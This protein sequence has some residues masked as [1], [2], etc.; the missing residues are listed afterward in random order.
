MSCS[1]DNFR[2]KFPEWKRDDIKLSSNPQENELTQWADA[3]NNEALEQGFDKPLF[4]FEYRYTDALG[5][6]T[7]R[8]NNVHPNRYLIVNTENHN[9][10]EQFLEEEYLPD[11]QYEQNMNDTFMQA[12]ETDVI[13]SE[14]ALT[15]QEDRIDYSY[16]DA[17][18]SAMPYDHTE[19]NEL[20]DEPVNFREWKETRINLLNS[21]NKA[22]S[23]L[24]NRKE[25]KTKL[26]QI[27]SAIKDLELEL[28]EFEDTNPN[29]VHYN[30]ISEIN[31]L[32]SLLSLNE[33]D[34]VQAAN[35]LDTNL[36]L[37]RLENLE[38]SFYNEAFA[39]GD[40]YN[41]HAG[42]KPE[43]VNEIVKKVIDLR[44]KYENS[45][46]HLIFNIINNNE[47]ILQQKQYFESQGREEEFNDFI[48]RVKQLLDP[49]NTEYKIDGD[50]LFGK[51]LLGAGSYDSILAEVII[52]TR[53]IHKSKEAGITNLWR[54]QLKDSYDK[55][56]AVKVGD[57]YFAD[58]LF[59]KDEFGVRTQKLIN[60]VTPDFYSKLKILSSANKEFYYSR[61]SDKGAAYKDWMTV[62][63]MNV[64][65]I[66]PHKI[67]SF[68]EKY[69][70]NPDFTEFFTSSQ[71]EMEA[72]EDNMRRNLGDTAFELELE[73][74]ISSVTDYLNDDFTTA[75]DKY[76]K[77]P[78]RY[79][80]N[81]YSDNFDKYDT[82]T[83]DFLLPN[84]V[85]FIPNLSN[86]E[87]YN[88]EFKNVENIGIEG[89]KDF[90]TS[91]KNLLDYTR[92]A[93][94]SEG[95]NVNFNDII[96]LRDSA[97]REVKKN[98]STFQGIWLDLKTIAK[99]LFS[100]FYEGRLE[101]VEDDKDYQRKFN[102]HYSNY[103]AKEINEMTT[104]LAGKNLQSLLELAEKE[105]ISVPEK[106][107][108][109]SDFNRAKIANSI[110]RN[111]INK[112]ISLDLF[113]RI[114]YGA[115]LAESINTR[116][117]TMS[118]LNLIKDYARTN[119]VKNTLSYVETWE[120]NNILQPGYLNH[121]RIGKLERVKMKWLPKVY[122][123]AEQDLIK[124]YEEE[125][126]N[127]DGN[128]NFVYQGFKYFTVNGEI[129]KQD[130]DANTVNRTTKA[131]VDA[132]YESY[133]TDKISNLGKNARVGTF[134]FGL[135][136]N[137]F[138]SYL[139]VSLPSG[140]KNRMAGYNQN[141]E[142][143]ASNL[144]GFN[145]DNLVNA[146]KLLG[147]TNIR[148]TLNYTGLPKTVGLINT[149]KAQQVDVLMHLVESLGLLEN[150]MSDA[151]AGDGSSSFIGQDKYNKFK[152]F[153]SDFAMNNPEFHNQ[154]EILVAMMQNVEITKKDGTP[155]KLYDPKTMSF[156][157][158]PKTMKLLDE[159]RTEENIKNWEQFIADDNGN[160]PQSILIQQFTNTKHKLHGNYRP[161]DKIGIQSTMTG[162][163]LT[164]FM[165]WAYEN[166]NNQYGTK[167]VSLATAQIEVKGRKIPII[168]RFPLLGTH[169]L[170]QNVGI[171]TMVGTTIGLVTG[172]TPLILGG[173]GVVNA[174]ILGYL[175][176]K[177]KKNVKF[178]WDDFSLS[179]NYLTEIL[180]RTLKTATL[181]TTRGLVNP[182]SES[183]I[184]NWS[185]RNE[186]TYKDRNLDLKTRRLIS[187]S[188]QEVAN[189]FNMSIQFMI[190]GLVLKA[191]YTLMFTAPGDDEEEKMKKLENIE[192][193]LKFL[194]NTKNNLTSDIEKW[195]NVSSMMDTYDQVILL[196]FAVDS[197]T[198]VI[199]A[200]MKYNEGKISEE[201]MY[202]NITEGITGPVFGVPRNAL[203]LVHP[204]KSLFSDN[205]IY[206]NA[207]KTWADDYLLNSHIK[208]EPK[209]KKLVN[210][211][212]NKIRLE[213]EGIYR[214]KLRE[215]FDKAGRSDY[216]NM[217][218]IIKTNISNLFEKNKVYAKDGR[219]N[220]AIYK[221]TDWS[222]IIDQA[223][224][225]KVSTSA[226]KKSSSKKS[227]NQGTSVSM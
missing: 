136:W 80:N 190:A 96:S 27:N 87:F 166:L 188:A 162:R 173:L 185:N 88:Q 113:K 1:L 75:S 19:T 110:A 98:L 17:L 197:W 221:K 145:M 36:I 18:F 153:M 195:T 56:K 107:K 86:P 119:E 222:S 210:S 226:K 147:G 177:N 35:I 84:Y 148:K 203:K 179:A 45:L 109:E 214:K 79:L 21:L 134:M 59:Q 212:R 50:S 111:R 54:K 142:A 140:L 205:R 159:Y 101:N 70:D 191:A 219:S 157:Y 131:E 62:N 34:P 58:L 187:E 189:K 207:S 215:E 168:T 217:D 61:L 127:V 132:I 95:I 55:I 149:K 3:A 30:V 22:K 47:L 209:Y 218:D 8:R 37:E 89:F 10:Y 20:F 139:W 160:A 74:Q 5:G 65:Y 152:E 94:K 126:Q 12:F 76:H 114:N 120:A 11:N 63:K 105:G 91:A 227:N 204:S 174:G 13:L 167:K 64:D 182:I 16:N 198:K 146:R 14:E 6:H 116:K 124:L 33:E 15:A 172:T 220:E 42:L 156:I 211:E 130:I 213:L 161:D 180:L 141:N 28:Q 206:D 121:E 25:N 225:G 40:A 170:V 102:T 81:F 83:G 2:S 155:G 224:S 78:L 199:E 154:M 183:T 223:K 115:T 32:N 176:Y 178:S 165:K 200:P 138:R 29:Y 135:A 175:M 67:K 123:E 128:Y 9:L 171:P 68:V 193:T 184:E 46:Q 60:Y 169:F 201:E 41:F 51:N 104:I 85:K 186:A 69:A 106:Y 150:V 71:A 77:N 216:H 38:Q 97:T 208:G 112:S 202:Y 117:N 151:D 108:D 122:T 196:K 103:G 44:A 24:L 26:K 72:Y 48:D 43:Q 31:T 125:K 194:I 144:H 92:E 53:D 129:N 90:Y 133:I 49:E 99:N 66:Q 100:E 192:G 82:S 52:I 93:A 39:T 164:A 143:G 181:T 7:D 73:K 4:S 137:M 57:E 23:K 158:D 118:I 163:G